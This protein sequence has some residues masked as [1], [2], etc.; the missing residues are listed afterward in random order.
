MAKSTNLLGAEH[1]LLHHII[2]THV[3]PTSG[4]HGRM[5]Y[6]DLYIM[7]HVV[8]GK[9]LNFPHLIMRN[10]LRASSKVDGALPYGMVITKIIAHF[11]ILPGNEVP[12]RIDVGDVYNA[13]SLKRMGWKRVLEARKGNVWL[14]KEGGRKRR[15]EEENVEEQGESQRPKTTPAPQHQASSNSYSLSLESILDEIKK[16]KTKMN[17]IDIKMDNLRGECLDLF[18]DQRRRQRRLKKKLVTKGVIEASDISSSDE[19]DEETDEEEEGTQE[20]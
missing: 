18:D 9:P 3:L 6:Q 5:S 4:G 2:T 8:T 15:I 12:S 13:S 16:L 19:E 20:K 7:W 14:P 10:M 11:G 1:R 17:K